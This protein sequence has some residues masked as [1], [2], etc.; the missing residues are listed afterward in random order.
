[1]NQGIT[2]NPIYIPATQTIIQSYSARYT[3]PTTGEVYGGTDYDNADKLAELGAVPL[4]TEEAGVGFDVDTWEVVDDPDNIGGKLRRPLTTTAW[5]I[6]TQ[7][8]AAKKEQIDEEL[9]R[10]I[11]E[12]TVVYNGWTFQ[13]KDRSITSIT[14]VVSAITAGVPVEDPFGWRDAD[15]VIHPLTHVQLIE[16]AAT[17][18]ATIN[19]IFNKS[20]ALKDTVT[21]LN[22]AIDFRAFDVKESGNW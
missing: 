17:M 15:D 20:F 22:S 6:T 3:H 2:M 13:A 21:A 1:M 10:R 19:P 9:A 7:D 16:L 11:E 5:T 4:R 18:F 12:T 8:L 14:R